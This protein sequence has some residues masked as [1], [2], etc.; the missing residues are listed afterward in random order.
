MPKTNALVKPYL[1]WA[2]GKRQLL[3]EIQKFI[4][5]LNKCRYYE[6]FIGA[7]AVFF[8]MQPKKAAI[9]D[10]NLQLMLTYGSIR[11][12]ID[13]L[14]D[15]L[16]IHKKNNSEDYFY[17]VR[18][19][20]RDEDAFGKLSAVEKSARLIYL[21]KTCYNGLYRV[22]AQGL[23]NAP[24]G[25]Y[26]KPAICDEPV[27]R[28]IHKYFSDSDLKITHVD[29]EDAVKSADEHSFVYFDPPYYSPDNTNFTGYQAGR[30]DED[31]Q[32][33][34][35]D[36]F[37]KLTERGVRCL[38]SNSDTKF[39]RRIYQSD[40]YEIIPVLAKRAINSDAA[41]RGNVKELLIKN[42]R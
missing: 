36:V 17:K 27:L 20:D 34:L 23:F 3:P 28:A 5:P 38:L 21:N 4:P 11:L 24:Y 35:G 41:G 39:I 15:V 1:K 10:L 26:Q 31:E 32:A 29:F 13:D 33:R 14:I 7:G 9:N 37:A 8:D 30:F 25:R 19:Q 6:P 2:G 16:K 12:H 42:W 40:R 22:N 18:E